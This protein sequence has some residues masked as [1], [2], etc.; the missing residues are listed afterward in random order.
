MDHTPQAQPNAHA[1]SSH[2]PALPTPRR[3]QGGR[4]RISNHHLR[5]KT[6]RHSRR[7]STHPEPSMKRDP[8]APPKPSTHKTSDHNGNRVYG[9]PDNHGEFFFAQKWTFLPIQ[10]LKVSTTP[11]AEIRLTSP[12]SSLEQL[13]L[14][15]CRAPQLRR[16]SADIYGSTWGP[17]RDGN[18]SGSGGRAVLPRRAAT[19]GMG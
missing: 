16:L 7:D 2:G 15:T 1:G 5:Q 11:D 9:L 10:R 3:R 12:R 8:R 6:S 19:A 17:T 14:G 4:D 18:W 13:A